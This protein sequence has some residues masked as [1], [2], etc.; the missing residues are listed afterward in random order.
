MPIEI[1]PKTNKTRAMIPNRRFR[2]SPFHQLVN[3]CRIPGFFSFLIIGAPKAVA[4]SCSV[5][6]GLRLVVFLFNRLG[7][8]KSLEFK[9]YPQSVKGKICRR[10][11]CVCYCEKVY[12]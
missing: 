7:N 3:F 12:L 5:A 4:S 10:V 6:G 2:F 9:L 1:A 8:R 11:T